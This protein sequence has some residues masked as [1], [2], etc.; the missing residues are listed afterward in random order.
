[1]RWP[2]FENIFFDCDSTLTTVE[3][4]D[5][6]ADSLGKGWRISV[7]T[8]AAMSGAVDL[9]DVYAKRLQALRPTRG[10]IHAL[11][12]VYKQNMVP[13]AAQIVATL[14]E[15]GHKV[16]IISGGL[17]EPV[18]EY[19]RHLGV[20]D[21]HI[22]AVPIRYDSLAGQWWRNTGEALNPAERYLSFGEEALTVSAGKADIVQQVLQGQPGRS[23]L[24]GDG[25][26]DLLAGEAVD[27][28]VGYG[29]VSRRSRVQA[30]APAFIH[31]ASLAPLLA[32]AIGPAVLVRLIESRHAQLSLKA[33]KLMES[34]AIT[35]R[36][37]PLKERFVRAYQ[38]VHTWTN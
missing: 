5:V 2:P 19:G 10:Q 16:Y 3:G 35:F 38:A 33:K 23:M 32:I 37:E 24:V 25:T 14:Q 12:D 36:D 29:G 6:L 28:F 13:D 26:S 27:L 17:R 22:H 34:G 20:P 7:L 11:R 30:Q 15:L 21:E 9:E 8:E 18:L 4:I 31:S 1:M